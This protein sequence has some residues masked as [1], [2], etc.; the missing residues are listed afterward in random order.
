MLRNTQQQ[1]LIRIKGRIGFPNLNLQDQICFEIPVLGIWSGFNLF[2]EDKSCGIILKYRALEFQRIRGPDWN[3]P[4]NSTSSMSESDFSGPV[5][6]SRCRGDLVVSDRSE[7]PPAVWFIDWPQ[8]RLH[9]LKW[10]LVFY[11]QP[12]T[13]RYAFTARGFALHERP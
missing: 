12:L 2:Q 1:C 11:W 13:A 7:P 8:M 5:E 4:K 10:L 3:S 6:A 9:W